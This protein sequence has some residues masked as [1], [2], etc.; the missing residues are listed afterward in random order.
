MTRTVD[1][2]VYGSLLVEFQ[3][4]VVETEEENEKYLEIIEKLMAQ[5]T[6]LQSKILSWIFW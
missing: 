2:N 1:K 6:A 4:K 5:K 3:P